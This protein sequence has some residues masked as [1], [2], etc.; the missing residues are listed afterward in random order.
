MLEFQHPPGGKAAFTEMPPET[1]A[2]SQGVSLVLQQRWLSVGRWVW[3]LQSCWGAWIWE[4][5]PPFLRA[6]QG[7][8]CLLA[9]PTLCHPPLS[10]LLPHA[11]I[12][13]FSFPSFSLSFLASGVPPPLPR[14]EAKEIRGASCLLSLMTFKFAYHPKPRTERVAAPSQSKNSHNGLHVLKPNCSK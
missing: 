3:L 12:D 13:S 5:L 4:D 6:I 7:I 9:T 8:R 14:K 10:S 1:W 11:G 2:A